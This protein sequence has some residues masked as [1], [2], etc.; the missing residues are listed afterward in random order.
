MAIDA[1]IAL[2]VKP[3]QLESPINQMA[4]MY[5]LQ[6]V[7]QSNKLNQMKMDEYSRGVAESEQFK[8][9]LRSLNR[10]SPTYAQDEEAAYAIKGIEGLKALETQR[11][12]RALADASKFEL[13]NKNF[14]A[15]RSALAGL[16][17]D[18]NLT[19]A[20]AVSTAQ[21]LVAAGVVPAN[22]A[23]MA[24]QL[25]DDPTA[26]R[27]ALKN[28]AR[29][30]LAPKDIFTTFAP[31]LAESDTGQAKVFIDKNPNSPTYGQTVK[32]LAKSATPGEVLSASN[33]RATQAETARHN[34][35][36]EGQGKIPAGYRLLSD[37]SLETIPGGPADAKTK[38]A[39]AGQS[40][41]D[42]LAATLNGYYDKLS[43]GGGIVS[44]NKRIGTNLGSSVQSSGLGQFVGGA[45]G[46]ENQTTRQNI[47]NARPL[48]LQAIMKATGMSAK[49]MD[50]NQ[51]L[52]LYLSAATDP[53]KSLESNKEA[54]DNLVRLYGV[55]GEATPGG[56]KTKPIMPRNEKMPSSN[57][58]ANKSD[59]QIKK[60]LGIK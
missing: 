59:A 60:E 3:V 7:V 50:S 40:T 9:A 32:T 14:N 37:G 38:V 2:G 27:A 22:F 5:E 6:N 8:N 23:T 30:Q 44:S 35:V 28:G 1:S 4:K 18:P 12:E 16:S 49:Q 34:V 45:V 41:V 25:P 54:L 53:S 46:T 15:Y 57:P 21:Q 19:K 56:A 51:E 13:A 26:L 20:L 36:M 17:T 33:Q 48:L 58:H 42:S 31:D 24:E 39:E 43:Q 47:L 11:K 52:K 29:A 10:T 55:G